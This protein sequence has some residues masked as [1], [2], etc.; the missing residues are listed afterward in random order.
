MTEHLYDRDNPKSNLRYKGTGIEGLFYGVPN[1]NER[2]E[3]IARAVAKESDGD[4]TKFVMQSQKPRDVAQKWRTFK[5]I[6]RFFKNPVGY[7]YWKMRPLHKQNRVRAIWVIL[8]AQLYFS[9]VAWI[10]T[11]NKKE[12]M[13]AF[14]MHSIGETSKEQ[15][16]PLDAKPFPADRHKNYLR[17]SN[18]HQ[19]LR[20]KRTSMIWTSWWCR[21]QNFRKY[22][23]M[24]KKHGI[25]PSLSGFYHEKIYDDYIKSR[26]SLHKKNQMRDYS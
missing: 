19:K 22:F 2:A 5:N 23:E 8:A 6:A 17:Y 24:R 11:K 26:V 12:S 25:R 15:G 13:M 3:M 10:G 7:A 14:W 16:L 4:L 9:F 18:F 1:I 20:N 21:D